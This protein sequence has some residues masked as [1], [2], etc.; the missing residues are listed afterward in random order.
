M[1]GSKSNVQSVS[2]VPPRIISELVERNP[3]MGRLL[4]DLEADDA[5]RARLEVELLRAAA[6]PTGS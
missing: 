5:L 4:M 1:I 2:T 3:G 6:P